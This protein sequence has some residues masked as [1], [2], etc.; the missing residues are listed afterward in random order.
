MKVFIKI[1]L[2]IIYCVITN[3]LFAQNKKCFIEFRM[4]SSVTATLYHT[5]IS[6]IQKG[7]LHKIGL[8]EKVAIDTGINCIIEFSNPGFIIPGIKN[9]KIYCDT[10]IF[11]GYKRLDAVVV[12]AKKTI[13]RQTLKGFEYSP[14]N[15]SVFKNRSLLLSLQRLPFIILK[16]ED[17]V[18]YTGGKIMFKINGREKKGIGNSWNSILKAINAKDIYKVEMIR[19]VPAFVKNQGYDVIIDILTLDANLYGKT[20]TAATFI[21]TRKNINPNVGFTML[22]KKADFSINAGNNNERLSTFLHTKVLEGEDIINENKITNNYRFHGYTLSLGYGLRIDSAND[23]AVNVSM[24]RNVEVNNFENHYTYPLPIN[25]QN[26]TFFNVNGN[27]DISYVHRRSKFITKS[28]IAKANFKTLEF[29]NRLAY[30]QPMKAD[31]IN[32]Q[33][34]TKPL[35][36]IVEY[37]HLNTKHETYNIEYGLQFYKKNY[38]QSFFYYTL[39]SSTN[40]NDQ[41]FFSKKDSMLLN[42]FGI[43]PYFK[44]DKDFSP[45]RNI[46]LSLSS[47]FYSISP[48]NFKRKY[49][50]LPQ[51][52]VSYK[53]LFKSNASLKYSM[54]FGY[55]KPSEDYFTGMQ[56][57]YNTPAES[58]QGSADIIPGKTIG[59]GVEYLSVKKATFSNELYVGYGFD[60]PDFITAFDSISKKIVTSSNNGGQDF[61]VGYKLN[62]QKLIAKKL[63]FSFYASIGWYNNS[64]NSIHTNTSGI[65]YRLQPI[66][67][68]FMGRKYGNINFFG[69]FN[70]N[71]VTS[72]GK[73]TG[74]MRYSLSYGRSIFKQKFSI[75][76]ILDEFLAKNRE[77]QSFSVFNGLSQ[78][79]TMGKP[80]R[81]LSIRLAYHF[82]NIKLSKFAQKKTTSLKGESHIN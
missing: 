22:H 29:N 11:I 28:L 27:I 35:Y 44:Y 67:N 33:S 23:F 63:N 45:K 57:N 3:G 75:V 26:Y 50:Y 9:L 47:E 30:T 12:E 17:A 16:N 21:N 78:Y 34:Q 42:Q 32:R 62:F 71:N 31:S 82:S 43:R 79:S 51:I 54:Y 5:K 64:N 60:N 38:S 72:Q 77:T 69:I 36:W 1:I 65:N 39:D 59:A 20:F 14:Q 41:L 53:T 70:G 24:Y 68:Y 52:D 15:D 46:V 74:P 40:D 48:N 7:Y 8:N 58:R 81:L 76:L 80:S 56:N 18:E 25:N 4:D 37:N 2:A 6:I 61:V 49:F 73:T 10:I 13:V 66:I 55:S 19:E